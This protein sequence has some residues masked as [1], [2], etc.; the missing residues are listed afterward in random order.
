MI[1]TNLKA[2]KRDKNKYVELVWKTS[3]KIQSLEKHH[4]LYIATFID[5]K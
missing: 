5:R 3:N 4:L 1:K 2:S